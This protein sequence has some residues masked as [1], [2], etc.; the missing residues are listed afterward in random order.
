VNPI[1]PASAKKAG[2]KG[3]ASVEAVITTAGC[4]S[5]VVVLRSAGDTLNFASLETVTSW[6]YAPAFLGGQA[7]E[8]LLSIDVAFN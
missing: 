5:D 7:V 3:T 4:V 2:M 6:R 8:V 1:Y